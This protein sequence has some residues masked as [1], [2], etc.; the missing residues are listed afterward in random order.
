MNDERTPDAESKEQLGGDATRP[1][2]I[3][4][5]DDTFG[6]VKETNEPKVKSP[7]ELDDALFAAI[8]CRLHSDEAR[9]LALIVAEMVGAHELAKGMRKNK[10]KKRQTALSTAVER[11]L[12]DLLLAQTSE[13]TKGYVYR[14]LRPGGFTESEVSYRIFRAL[15]EALVDL[16]LLESRKGFQ[17]WEESFGGPKVADDPEGNTLPGDTEA[18]GHL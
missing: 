1:A 4:S 16:G 6:H 18:I 5:A 13:K 10:R 14:S 17:N 3:N 15:V 7:S 12:A 11:L 8:V 2:R 9:A